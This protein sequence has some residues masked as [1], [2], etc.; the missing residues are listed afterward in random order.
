ML[1]TLTTIIIWFNWNTFESD[2][3][4]FPHLEMT[5]FLEMKAHHTY[6]TI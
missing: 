2:R 1:N 3:K 6:F 4:I 5:E